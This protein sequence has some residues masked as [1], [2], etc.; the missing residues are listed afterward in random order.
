MACYQAEQLKEQGNAA[1]RNGEYLEAVDLYT[2]AVQKY[3][4][5]PLIF[6]NRANSRLRLQQWDGAVN[7]CSK[8]IELTGVNGHN[9]KAWYFLGEQAVPIT[10]SKLYHKPSSSTLS[11]FS[12]LQLLMQYPSPS[13]TRS[14]PSQ[15]SLSLSSDRL[16]PSPAPPAR[17]KDLPQGPGNL[18]RLRAQM[19][20]SQIRRARP[21][22]PT[23]TRRPPRRDRKHAAN[24]TPTRARRSHRPAPPRRPR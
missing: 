2:Q 14:E 24:S 18:L 10:L 15:R 5:N 8:S 23:T 22:S 7:D 1:F 19:Q 17:R 3:S 20:E 6:T 13:T 4:R 21:R 16:R 11:I 12:I 9:H